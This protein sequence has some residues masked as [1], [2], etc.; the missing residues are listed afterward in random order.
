MALFQGG[1]NQE[2]TAPSEKIEY[3]LNHMEVST[4]GHVFQRNNTP[5]GERIRLLHGTTGNFIDFD[6]KR[7]TYL[8]SYN[9]T[10][11]ETDHNM[12]VKIGKNLKEDKLVIQVVGDVHM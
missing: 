4:C 1:T 2:N 6:E 10:N 11:V 9:N 3:P 12:T 7:D 5:D 8:I